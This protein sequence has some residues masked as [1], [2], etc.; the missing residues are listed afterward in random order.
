VCYKEASSEEKQLLAQIFYTVELLFYLLN[1][2][3][4]TL[5]V[6]LKCERQTDRHLTVSKGFCDSSKLTSQIPLI[7]VDQKTD[8]KGM[9]MAIFFLL[10]MFFVCLFALAVILT[11]VGFQILFCCYTPVLKVELLTWR[12]E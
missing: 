11:K 1:M 4:E 10:T 2:V 6:S 8:K 12:L 9:S 3:P 7:I 5:I